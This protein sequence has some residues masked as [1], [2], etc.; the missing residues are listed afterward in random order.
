[1]QRAENTDLLRRAHAHDAARAGDGVGGGV[2]VGGGGGRRARADGSERC[3]EQ[4]DELRS[5]VGEM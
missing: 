3:E 5:K 2:A 1:M 4:I